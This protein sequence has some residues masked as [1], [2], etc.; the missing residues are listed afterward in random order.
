MAGRLRRV[1]PATRSRA[2]R[3]FVVA[4]ILA[5]PLAAPF[6]APSS[7]APAVA[8]RAASPQEYLSLGMPL[9]ARRAFLALPAAAR[10]KSTILPELLEKLSEA[11]HAEDAL[12][13]FAAVRQELPGPARARAFLAAGKIHWARKEFGMAAEAFR[14]ARRIPEAALFLARIQ[15]AGGDAAGAL[16]TLAAA[17]PGERQARVAAA[18]EGMKRQPDAAALRA[19]AGNARAGT[20]AHAAATAALARA[21]LRSGDDRGALAAAREGIAGMAL[22]REAVARLGAWDGSREDAARTWTSMADLFP[23]DSDVGAFF[24]AGGAFLAAADLADTARAA[25]N[26]A[27]AI[28]RGAEWTRRVLVPARRAL[29]E[30]ARRA[31]EIGARSR[32]LD[33]SA[34]DIRARAR[35]AA[36]AFP[37]AAWGAR[38]DPAGAVLLA[39]LDAA[40]AALRSRLERTRAATGGGEREDGGRT[41]SPDDRRM[42]LFA[43][44][45]AERA[46]DEVRVLE[47]RAAF[48]RGRIL[49]RWKASY[50]DRLSGILDG[51]DRARDEALEGAR[52]A[53]EAA[54]PLRS[55]RAGLAQWEEAAARY[56]AR[57]AADGAALGALREKARTAAENALGG[58]RRELAAAVAG[59]ERSLRY[60]AARA[61]TGILN[62]DKRETP[63]RAPADRAGIL[64]E[65]RGHWEA[66]LSPPGGRRAPADE[67]TYALAE[68]GFE[69]AEARF[70]GPDG[71]G[72]GHPDYAAAAA[73]FRKVVEEFP[74]SPYAEP[75]HYGLA[76][77][78]QEM[79]AP[80]NSAAVLEA[81][82]A[83]Y[84]KTR[85][86][87]EIHLR[88]GERAFD[89]GEFRL[90]EAHY[91]EVGPGAPADV[92]AT[93]WL[94]LGW[95]LVLTERS[96][97]SADFFLSALEAA[98]GPR[99]SG[100]AGEAL[101]MAARALV[102]A[103]L[104]DRA[105]ALLAARGAAA[106]GPALLLGVQAV[107][108]A[109]NRYDE[110]AAI[111]D[112]IGA[113]YPLAEGR[114][115][116][117]V[118]AAEALRK[119][120]RADESFARRGN[121]HVL[122]GPGSR[123]QAAPGRTPGD[124]ARADVIAEEGLRSAAFHFHARTREGAPGTVRGVPASRE[125]VLALYDAYRARFPAAPGADEVS[126][127][128]AWLLFEAGRKSEA[129]AA[130]EAAARRP[131]AA[132]GESSR[133]MAVQC[134]KD[135]ASLAEGE[136]PERRAAALDDVIRLCGEYERAFPRGDRLPDILLD[137]ARAAFR[138]RRFPD[139]ARDA[140]RAA[141]LLVAEAAR[142]EALRLAGSARFETEDYGRAETAF[143][144]LLAASPPP[145]ERK[146]AERWVGFSM[147]R[148][149]ERLP[150]A[151][152]AEAARIFS[153]LA[154]EFPS[155]EIAPAALFRAG[156][157]AAEAGNANDA[158]AAF[159]AVE[160]AGADPGLA[161]D[162]T[163]WLASLYEKTG[164]K[165]AA[166]ARYEKLADSGQAG[167][168][169]GPLLLRAAGLLAGVDEPRARKDLAAVA[170]LADSPPA[171]RV[172]CYFRAAESA[173]ADG[174]SDEADDLYGKATAAHEAAP[175]AAP[176][177]AGKAYFARAEL[178]F[179]R[180]KALSIAPPLEKSFAEK[181]AALEA[182]AELYVAA[183]RIGDPETAPAALHRLGEGFEDFRGAILASPAPRGLS[184]AER[185]EYV[186][187]LEEKAAPLEEQAV[188]AYRRNLRN[189]VA[190]GLSSPW[191]D[192]SVAR[193][194]GLRPALFARRW[195]Y[196]FPVV[197]V[198]D[199]LGIIVREGR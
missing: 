108:D 168:Q 59:E 177:I 51:V 62:A 63:G 2:G 122:F 6:P 72:A 65:A 105:G 163:Q 158:I 167:S 7:A 23:D 181:R 24:A 161:R 27:V 136:P 166:A 127:Q 189:A 117:E 67:A 102:D 193:L 56:A 100:I 149:A 178:R 120:G 185:E 44:K 89:R 176:G 46:D 26:G 5:A 148:R 49:N 194:K 130:F 115:D 98:P 154:R 174:R 96:R 76:L 78:W 128:R 80:D 53:D 196:A 171:L 197:P 83:R 38:S 175:E 125:S 25:G 48:L 140:D 36:A 172:T 186:F 84:P 184:D 138:A 142:R 29:E 12:S 99:S 131:G 8:L 132:R 118:A 111:A 40:L 147:F 139:A 28:A 146:D 199:F 129:G 10:A 191:V 109:Q 11:G 9:S 50:A 54:R 152:A 164:E 192:R 37:I 95:T 55:A 182:A 68:L 86:A 165:A 101:K 22:R 35:D 74:E 157:A 195:E 180:Y 113:A 169:K 66:V 141:S 33:A 75:A 179:A 156:A 16:R 31:A 90:A 18:I 188:D 34:G 173:R 82:L 159:L 69:D 187:L 137:R 198:P 97:E 91:R 104:W 15:V 58:A 170:A 107:L 124:I 42:L 88:L 17:P 110:A 71:S 114:I 103:N 160:S 123:W 4:A 1:P 45:K 14:E 106:H 81:M 162:A 126:Y 150:P 57:L 61:A 30:K 13:L 135:A 144:T 41:L 70:Y 87:D 73:L 153:G 85:H 183:I 190:A 143:R 32:A 93:A 47:G 133:Y 112:R 151:A 134:A 60:L 92:R 116:A 3:V 43:R 21:L 20:S 52:R 39:R 94:K 77:C 119:A 79:G 155:L 19:A 64:A 121:Y 145:E